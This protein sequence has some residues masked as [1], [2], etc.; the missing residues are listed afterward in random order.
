[1]GDWREEVVLRREDNEALRVYTTTMPTA[2]R[3][4]TLMHDPVYRVAVSWQNSSY[5][6]P[7]HPG[8]YMATDMDFPPPVPKVKV[9]SRGK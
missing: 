3:L 4:Y 9:L 7:P 8:Y 2:H 1:M 5:N 6:Q